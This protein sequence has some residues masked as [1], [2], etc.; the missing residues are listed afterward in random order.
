MRPV[1]AAFG[2][3]AALAGPAFAQTAESA[4]A[5]PAER[6]FSPFLEPGFDDGRRTPREAAG[7]LGDDRRGIA[8]GTE[9]GF[10]AL[11]TPGTRG[12][13]RS[14]RPRA[15]SPFDAPEGG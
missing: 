9:F 4:P 10:D 1:L 5:A 6:E 11:L 8:S 2:L 3:L 14:L 7:G 12:A 15:R 13:K